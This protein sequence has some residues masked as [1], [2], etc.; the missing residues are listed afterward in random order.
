M[1]SWVSEFFEL[2]PDA[3]KVEETK[4]KKGKEYKNDLFKDVL[5]ALSRSDKKF[6]SRLNDEQKKEISIW[7]LSRWISWED[8]GEY[9]LSVNYFSN[10]DSKIFNSKTTK[11]ALETNKHKELQWMLLATASRKKGKVIYSRPAIPKGIKKNLIEEFILK[12]YPHFDDTELELFL[13]INSGEELEQFL[14]DN[15]FDDKTIKEL[16]TKGK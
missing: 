10:V 16:L 4:E 1:S 11:N 3:V 8:S 6:Y 15:G 14:K 12:L 5:P 9:L 13:K 2:N 7:M